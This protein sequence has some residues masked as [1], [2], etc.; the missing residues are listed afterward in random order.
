MCSNTGTRK[1][2]QTMFYYHPINNPKWSIMIKHVENSLI[3]IFGLVFPIEVIN[4]DIFQNA[5]PKLS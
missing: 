1:N 3:A 4:L 2:D 5:S